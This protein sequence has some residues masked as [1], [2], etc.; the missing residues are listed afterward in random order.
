[1]AE[2]EHSA[3]VYA[4]SIEFSPTQSS[5]ARQLQTDTME[6]AW[7]I[8]DGARACAPAALDEAELQKVRYQREI[9]AGLIEDAYNDAVILRRQLHQLHNRMNYLRKHTQCAGTHA[10]MP[11]SDATAP[12][13]Q[14]LPPFN[15]LLL[16]IH[17][18]T[19]SA[20]LSDAYRQRIEKLADQLESRHDTWRLELY[21]N[22]DDRADTDYNTALA[23][24]RA[25]A[26]AEALRIAGIA[27]AN[28]HI[29]ISGESS[30]LLTEPIESA[31]TFNR[32]VDIWLVS[33]TS[34]VTTHATSP[35]EKPKIIPLKTWPEIFS[36]SKSTNVQEAQQ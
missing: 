33:D 16:E 1:M 30:P 20:M 14:P 9:N 28:I 11:S 27:E 21:A 24:Q 31:R 34:P 4:V 18:D 17:F 29:A 13:H 5:L 25:N 36:E 12:V 6:I 7:L 35:E 22:S 8:E 32:R 26:V 3:D 2:Y 23:E 10:S 19:A 15:P